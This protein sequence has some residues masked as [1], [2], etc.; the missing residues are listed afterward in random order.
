MAGDF[1]KNNTKN[2]HFR[3]GT[4][5]PRRRGPHQARFWLDGVETPSSGQPAPARRQLASGRPAPHW[6]A[7]IIPVCFPSSASPLAGDD[8][9]SGASLGWADGAFAPRRSSKPRPFQNGIETRLFPQPLQHVRENCG[10]R[11]RVFRASFASVPIS[12]SQPMNPAVP[13][14]HAITRASIPLTGLPR[15]SPRV[16]VPPILL[17]ASCSIPPELQPQTGPAG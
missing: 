16:L 17:P 6:Q 4:R 5:R 1:P 8:S 2:L 7:V 12:D 10:R 11:T 9:R 15:L 14:S 3:D 13:S